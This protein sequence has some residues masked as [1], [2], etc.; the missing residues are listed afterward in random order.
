MG[1]NPINISVLPYL[2]SCFGFD[3]L[4]HVLCYLTSCIGL[5]PFKIR[6]SLL[7][8]KLFWAWSH[9]ILSTL[10]YLTS[11]FGLDPIQHVLCYSTSCIGPH[12]FSNNWPFSFKPVVLSLLPI[13]TKCILFQKLFWASSHSNLRCFLLLIL[14]YWVWSHST[15]CVFIYYLTSCIGPDPLLH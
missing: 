10:P 11:C 9:S 6:N 1:P 7:L 14:L 5:I 13:N 15:L 8:N 2:T 12:L 4:Q 3:P